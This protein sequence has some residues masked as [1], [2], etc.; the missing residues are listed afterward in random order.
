MTP[1]GG[2]DAVAQR[3]TLV[4][5]ALS[6]ASHAHA[7]YLRNASGGR[8]YIDHPVAVAE[9]LAGMG[10]GEEVLAAALLHDVVEDSEIEVADVRERFGGKVAGLVE[11][12]TEDETIEPYEERKEEHRRRVAA[13]GPEA[14]AI[15]AADKLTNVSMLRDAYA[16]AGEDVGRELK[17][18]LDLKAQIWHADLEMLLGDGLDLDP[19][20]ARRLA[21]ELAG[22]SRDRQAAR[23]GEEQPARDGEDQAARRA[24]SA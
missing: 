4:R 20:L 14:L 7:G 15:Y 19:S 23:R 1:T 3:S 6:T 10:F 12:L 8:P 22:L 21:D 17:V 24:A 13:A 2:I 11:A 5:D 18:P 9:L 16:L